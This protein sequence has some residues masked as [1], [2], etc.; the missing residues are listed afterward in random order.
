VQ[1]ALLPA[2]GAQR[3]PARDPYL[4]ENTA[5]CSPESRSSR[6]GSTRLLSNHA[7]NT[8][9][10]QFSSTSSAAVQRELLVAVGP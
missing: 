3:A 8:M 1:A 5:D 9:Q 10:Q 2:S 7:L 6:S 4:S